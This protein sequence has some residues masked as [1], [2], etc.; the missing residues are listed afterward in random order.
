MTNNEH[1]DP[2]F[3]NLYDE[4]Q[5]TCKKFSDKPCLG[6]REKLGVEE[7]LQP[8]G[9]YLKKLTLKNEYAWSSYTATIEKM[10]SVSN[11]LLFQGLKSNDN[12]VLFMETRAEWLITAFSCFRIKVP[13]VTLYA[14]LGVEALSFGVNQ[15]ETKVLVTS[16]D[17][18]EKLGSIIGEIPTVT[19]VVVVC[20]QVNSSGYEKFKALAAKHEKKVLTF[21]EIVEEGQN[22][23]VITD[24]QT[25]EKNDL[26]IIMYTSGSTGNPKVNLKSEEID[27]DN[28]LP[29]VLV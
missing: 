20:D 28:V 10:N 18:L 15:T 26:A 11:G 5:K 22:N 24:F 6:V 8:N 21:N 4:V 25:P 16:G 9:K 29:T 19:H 12:I 3:K 7:E 23:P 1:L 13:V 27:R 2:N 14:T 17:C